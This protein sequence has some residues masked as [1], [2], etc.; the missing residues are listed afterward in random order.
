M[1]F[2]ISAEMGRRGESFRPF[3]REFDAIEN[4]KQ[5][6]VSQGQLFVD[7]V[8]GVGHRVVENADL[9]ANIAQNGVD[10]A[11]IRRFAG[12]HRR[13]VGVQV[14][15]YDGAVDDSIDER[16]PLFGEPALVFHRRVLICSVKLRS[17]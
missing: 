13:Y 11:P 4:W 9:L 10:H 2:E 3:R 5:I 14:R 16:H 15:A 1:L 17:R 8:S 6:K 7:Q 12:V